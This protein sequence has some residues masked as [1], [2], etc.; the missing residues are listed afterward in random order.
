[1]SIYLFIQITLLLVKVT[2]QLDVRFLADHQYTSVYATQDYS[3][4]YHKIPI[5]NLLDTSLPQQSFTITAKFDSKQ[6]ISGV[7]SSLM[8]IALNSDPTTYFMNVQFD[9][10]QSPIQ[11]QIEESASSSLSDQSFSYP[12]FFNSGVHEIAISFNQITSISYQISFVFRNS[13]D[14]NI[15]NTFTQ[16]SQITITDLSLYTLFLSSFQLNLSSE[17]Y[18]GSVYKVFSVRNLFIDFTTNYELS[19]FSLMLSEQ[20]QEFFTLFKYFVKDQLDTKNCIPDESFYS[21]N[22]FYF[23][24]SP[25][26][27]YGTGY[28]TFYGGNYLYTS[29]SM[30]KYFSYY[31]LNNPALFMTISFW[32]YLQSVDPISNSQSPLMTFYLGNQQFLSVFY[33]Y[34]SSNQYQIKIQWSN[35]QQITDLTQ[36]TLNVQQYY[37]ILVSYYNFSRQ[38]LQVLIYDSNTLQLN[39]NQNSGPLNF[40]LGTQTQDLLINFGDTLSKIPSGS[41]YRISQYS[42]NLSSSII[43]TPSIAS[44]II[45]N[46]EVAIYVRNTF[47][48]LL[49]QANYFLLNNAC[50]IQCNLNTHNQVQEIR[51]CIPK[52]SYKCSS[53]DPSTPSTCNLCSSSDRDSTINCLCKIGYEDF[54]SINCQKNT[55]SV[56]SFIVDDYY[57]TIVSN[58]WAV[59]KGFNN[60]FTQTPFL[61]LSITKVA[62]DLSDIKAV[63]VANSQITTTSYS[64][65]L[66]GSF[67]K[68]GGFFNTD[69]H[70]QVIVIP[71]TTQYN[72][73]V[74]NFIIS[75]SNTLSQ[76]YS[77]GNYDFQTYG[78]YQILTF[79]SGIQF[80]NN[81][82][83]T[84]TSL[85]LSIQTDL[86][87]KLILVTASQIQQI[88]ITYLICPSDMPSLY[89]NSQ[90]TQNP[91]IYIDPT[92]KHYQKTHISNY[93]LNGIMSD[94]TSLRYKNIYGLTG[95][96][97]SFLQSSQFIDYELIPRSNPAIQQIRLSMK[98]YELFQYSGNI[99]YLALPYNQYD[100]CQTRDFQTKACFFCKQAYLNFNDNCQTANA[101]VQIT[102]TD[103]FDKLVISFPYAISTYGYQ[104]PEN[105]NLLCK[106]IFDSSTYQKLA[107]SSLCLIQLNAINVI[108][109]YDATIFS[110]DT[111]NFNNV[112]MVT[113]Y[114][115]LIINYNGN[116]VTQSNLPQPDVVLDYQPIIN[117]CDNLKIVIKQFLNTVNKGV[118]N[119]YW[120]LDSV[121]PNIQALS[122]N[123][124]QIL[125]SVNTNQTPTIFVPLEYFIQEVQI[126]FTLAYQYKIKTSSSKSISI[127]VLGQTQ[128]NIAGRQLV[129]GPYYLKDLITIYFDAFIVMCN[130]NRVQLIDTQQSINVN[131]QES[132]LGL[133]NNL[134]LSNNR[135][136]QQ[137]LQPY[138]LQVNTQYNFQLT[139]QTDSGIQ[140]TSSY[141]IIISNCPLIVQIQGGN[142]IQNYSDQLILTSDIRDLD[143]NQSITQDQQIQYTWSCIDLQTQAACKDIEQ[144]IIP[145]PQ[146]S[147][148]LKFDPLT[149]KE[150]TNIQFTLVGNKDTRTSSSQ[151]VISF[152]DNSIP[153]SLI[154][155]KDDILIRNSINLNDVIEAT[156]Q[157]DS[158]QDVNLLFFGGAIIYQNQVVASM[159]FEYGKVRF[160]IWNYF[161]QFVPTNHQIV[162]RFSV[163]NPKYSIPSQS[164]YQFKLNFPPYNCQF[165]SVPI[166]GNS[167]QT[168]F[169]LVL[170]SCQSNNMPIS[171]K[172]FY[173]TSQDLYKLEV[174]NPLLVQRKQ[175]TDLTYLSQVETFLPPG[176]ILILVQAID[177]LGA[178]YNVTQLIQVS[179]SAFDQN[180]YIQAVNNMIQYSQTQSKLTQILT[181]S[182]LSEDIISRP[183]FYPAIQQ[184]IGY[185]Y[186]QLMNLTTN[187]YQQSTFSTLATQQISK[188]TQGSINK[189][190][191][192]TFDDIL[193]YIQQ[194][195]KVIQSQLSQ[196]SQIQYLKDLYNQQIYNAF[197][198]LDQST[199]LV[200][201][202][203]T[204]QATIVQLSQQIGNLLNLDALPNENQ[205][206]FNGSN[207]LV[208]SQLVTSKNLPI[209]LDQSLYDSTWQSNIQQLPPFQEKLNQVY[210]VSYKQ[211]NKNLYMN[212]QPFQD[213]LKEIQKNQT[214]YT[215]KNYSVVDPQI[216][217]IENQKNLVP[218]KQVSFTF[219]PIKN[220]TLNCINRNNN[221][222]TTDGCKTV[223]NIQLNSYD[224]VCD[225]LNPVTVFNSIENIFTNNTNI[226]TIF[227]GQG[228]DNISNFDNFYKYISFWEIG[229]LTL[230]FIILFIYGAFLD[231]KSLLKSPYLVTKVFDEDLK[232]NKEKIELKSKEN[233]IQI[234]QQKILKK[235][236]MEQEKF[237]KPSNV[238]N[239]IENKSSHSINLVQSQI[240]QVDMHH[241]IND[242]Q[243][244][245]IL[246][247]Q[248]SPFIPQK[249]L[250]QNNQ[251]NTNEDREQHKDIE[252]T[253]RDINPATPLQVCLNSEKN[254]I[255]NQQS[256][257]SK[258]KKLESINILKGIL[259]FHDIFSV[260]LI[261]DEQLSRFSRFL[262]Q[263]VRILHIYVSNIIFNQNY[264]AVQVAFIQIANIIV[265][266]I[267][268][269]IIE[270]GYSRKGIIQKI[271]K[272][273]IFLLVLFYYYA[274]F[275]IVS[276]QDPSSTNEISLKFLGTL[277]IGVLATDIFFAILL[278][279]VGI[280]L[281]TKQDLKGIYQKLYDLIKLQLILQNI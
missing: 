95:I 145:I 48:C 224:C 9:F 57:D 90:I 276:G 67:N 262:V 15:S 164:I 17:F 222:W 72:S 269:K 115:A 111:V 148:V 6:T 209:Y 122:D 236:D 150:Y 16:A 184:Q 169:S 227:S 134:S 100:N 199:S 121:V 108:L 47:V 40:N 114:Q 50:L 216:Q 62:S 80:G 229:A 29:I 105:S 22:C 258:Q 247:T 76:Q 102:L 263:Y 88:Q 27:S 163:Y 83:Q 58:Y 71:N 154:N 44:S 116:T 165:G 191:Q 278:R 106:Y 266:T 28:A 35:Q 32:F 79:I 260:F 171:Y 137:V 52:C 12:N 197:N 212:E 94:I 124:Q 204:I 245:E 78:Q 253:K 20:A 34:V 252:F 18:Q 173:Y 190:T 244:T 270:F 19:Q 192:I 70:L 264:T 123:L 96:Q 228:V 246:I 281:A 11:L 66:Q 207:I 14:N 135:S 200:S 101:Q 26:T 277:L 103:I 215:I 188:M 237:S 129:E 151:V 136:F 177:S 21:Q 126:S 59:S 156:I 181:L 240:Q 84:Q 1:M 74:L 63:T 75:D 265:V 128:I 142:R 54:M 118:S 5:S 221:Q 144:N 233:Q 254:L 77:L 143:L 38:S 42:I 203:S 2:S 85:S 219:K 49:C 234:E 97:T 91:G 92:L 214:S 218:P 51:S 10:T 89:H 232:L 30:Q 256:K 141:Y 159:E 130:Q 170:S 61:I 113:E 250:G 117:Q 198:I 168:I 241:K 120:T 155:F 60:G 167:I 176:D 104:G 132:I 189:S 147:M 280:K 33:Y 112:I 226:K 238:Q 186:S 231:K 251:K 152:I 119:F 279:Y 8:Y 157:Y 166:K 217:T 249:L 259:Y 160:Q 201:D 195:L 93:T 25:I 185:I 153:Q 41:F 180:S 109:D 255:E 107:Q 274:F 271:L 3:D 208:V 127:Q 174:K 39:Q 140:G 99:L 206:Q 257:D 98:S 45:N 65:Q 23:N 175:I 242:Q 73:G 194:L 183:N 43:Y 131:I 138:S 272:F 243:N 133:N 149:F 37:F 223:Y 261:Y 230:L 31:Q 55:N 86:T 179:Q 193:N 87:N 178:I 110:G 46:C 172:F 220:E 182:L 275:A 64:V 69:F 267:I 211:Y 273:I 213:F 225:N 268:T 161:S 36:F 56:L 146:N 235:E 196:D 53:C 125:N 162:L 239:D 24:Q 205:K 202:N 158:N 7:K 68:N 82:G 81:A 139:F 187:E 13:I 248:S 210:Q 4:N